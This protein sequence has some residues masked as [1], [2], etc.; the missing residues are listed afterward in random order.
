MRSFGPYEHSA[1]ASTTED[2]LKTEALHCRL[3]VSSTMWA[4]PQEVYNVL[5]TLASVSR[6]AVC[7]H[8]LHADC[9]LKLIKRQCI[10]G[11]SCRKQVS[12]DNIWPGIMLE[13][14]AAP[15]YG[16]SAGDMALDAGAAP[17]EPV[18]VRVQWCSGCYC[19]RAGCQFVHR[20]CT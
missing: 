8:Q 10:G 5:D 1:G 4:N 9:S 16:Y 15:A 17:L 6:P 20:V 11:L 3:H 19:Y 12:M 2:M 18:S 13:P 7:A 14:A